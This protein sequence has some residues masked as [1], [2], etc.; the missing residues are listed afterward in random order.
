[1]T[2]KAGREKP[3]LLYHPWVFSGA[4]DEIDSD[5][6]DGTTV[7]VFSSA[8]KWLARGYLN[9][10]SQIRVRLLTWN[11]EEK[12]DREFWKR[13]LSRALAA[14]DTLT[15]SLS[16]SAYRLVHAESDGIPGLVVDRYGEWLAVQ[17]L[18][19]GI[20]RNREVI[21]ELLMELARPRGIHERSDVAVRRQE[22]LKRHAGPL[23]GEPV[24]ALV[25]VEEHGHRF[26]VDIASGQKTG[27]YLDQRDNRLRVSGYATGA[28]VLNCFA[29]TGSFAVYTLTAGARHVTNVE[30]SYASLELAERNLSINGFD[31]DAQAQQ[32]A[33]SVFDVLRDF[34]AMGRNFDLVILDPPKFVRAKS[35]LQTGTRGYKD[36]N[37]L[38]LRLL[39]PGGILAT[40]SCSGLV[41]PDLFQKVVFGASVDARREVQ[42]LERLAQPPDHPVL[43]SF[44]EGAY[45]KG[46]VCRVW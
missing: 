5:A 16:T 27:F 12:I 36:I 35:R 14:R 33:G 1:V 26:A 20:D 40:F 24:P 19:L 37:L 44:P 25:Q 18:T 31:P 3:V 13:R 9:R 29:Y 8:G 7:D 38:A 10:R 39:R 17:F 28:D 6:V 15:G 4:I 41:S 43:L 32:L 2:L 11:D 34:S 45:L 30:S 22:G 23:A 21:S 42:I 46:L